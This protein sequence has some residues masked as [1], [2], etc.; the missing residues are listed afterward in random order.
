MPGRRTPLLRA[1]R[2]LADVHRAI[3]DDRS[4]SL[5]E[6]IAV[7]ERLVSRRRLLQAGG[8]V[9]AAALLPPLG[10]GVWPSRRARGDP[11]IV[12]V[13]AGLA[14]L[15]CAYKLAQHELASDVYEARDRVGGRCWTARGFAAGQVA[16]HGGEF[17]DTRHHQL[18]RLIATLG[19]ELDDLFAAYDAEAPTSG[20]LVLDG[21][22]RAP[23]LV[24]EDIDLVIR[25]LARVA[26]R[27]GPYRW[28]QA[29][30]Q[31]RAFD[32]VT[33]RAWLDRH[34]PGGSGSL[35]G[36]AMDVGL[37][38]FWGIDPDDT[39]AITLLDTYIT[40]YP[41]GAADERYHVRGGND[42]VPTL[43]F[44]RLADGS[45]HLEAPLRAVVERADGSFALTFDG[46]AGD[47]V[48]DVLVLTLPFTALREV[49]LTRVD[50]SRR[51]RRSIDEL[52][53]GTNAKVLVPFDRRLTELT[54]PRGR[55]WNGYFLTDEPQGDSWD[56]SLGQPGPAGLLTIYTGG[57]RGASYPATVPH[58][59]APAS[60]VDEALGFLDAWMPGSAGAYAGGAWLDAWVDDPWVRGSYAAFLPGQ[61]TSFSGYLGRASGNVHF[62]GEHTSTYSQGYL[63][64]GV[65]SGL[66]AAREV[67]RSA[68]RA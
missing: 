37:T 16:E 21:D 62:A 49:D 47:V 38:G 22:V 60:V 33:M 32:R 5:D 41:G 31:A 42:Q 27:I 9:A 3:G 35:L 54:T 46:I 2:E 65:E 25:Q 29:G 11:R 26:A 55:P 44:E 6:A 66:R 48:A 40:P 14:G 39:S 52:G 68:G 19:L 63:N 64:G 28:G 1:M 51:R 30:P 53:M 61:W 36:R 57:T 24:Y 13:G 56:S 67:L 8:A 7:R 12:V 59:P 45:V 17:V 15:S 10:A 20:L 18:R 34:V 58:G 50:L 43:L 23:G 4:I